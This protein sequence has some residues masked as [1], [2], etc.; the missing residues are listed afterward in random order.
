MI[1]ALIPPFVPRSMMMDRPRV[2]DCANAARRSGP[3]SADR[4]TAASIVIAGIE[5]RSAGAASSITESPIA[6]TG[7]LMMWW[8]G[9]FFIRCA[10]RR[11]TAVVVVVGDTVVDTGALR[12]RGCPD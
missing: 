12:A 11:G 10:A 2:P 1:D 6:V 9:C 5:R 3:G 7:T 8:F 4:F